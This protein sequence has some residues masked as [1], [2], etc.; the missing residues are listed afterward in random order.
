[1]HLSSSALAFL[2]SV[3]GLVSASDTC[4]GTVHTNPAD[5]TLSNTARTASRDELPVGIDSEWTSSNR[6]GKLKSHVELTYEDNNKFRFNIILD[7]TFAA[8]LTFTLAA[9]KN[10][11]VVRWYAL[12]VPVGEPLNDCVED[13]AQH[14]TDPDI[15]F[16]MQVQGLPA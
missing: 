16:F 7:S 9:V 5:W 8:G 6:Y 3:F 11:K 2:G 13:V 12:G 4:H 14:Y 15:V 10:N 1:M